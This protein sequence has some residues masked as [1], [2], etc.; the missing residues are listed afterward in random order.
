M[1][2]GFS[3]QVFDRKTRHTNTRG[4]AGASPEDAAL[5]MSRGELLRG[6]QMLQRCSPGSLNHLQQRNV[7]TGRERGGRAGL[8]RESVCQTSSS[9]YTPPPPHTHFCSSTV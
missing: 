1:G 6:A 3:P 4:R 9:A 7:R 5:Q 2:R 8:W